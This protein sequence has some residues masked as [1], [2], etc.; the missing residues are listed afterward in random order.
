MQAWFDDGA[1]L[2]VDD[3][4]IWTGADTWSYRTNGVA[5]N[6][7]A[8]TFNAIAGKPYRFRLDYMHVNDAAVKGP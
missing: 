6:A 3:K 7:P 4:L 8:G 5:M 2:Y 1:R